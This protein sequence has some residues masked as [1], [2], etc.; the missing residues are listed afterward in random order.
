MTTYYFADDGNDGNSGLTTSLPK[1][2]LSHAATL[3]AAGN[4]ILFKCGDRWQLASGT[5]GWAITGK[6]L[7]SECLIGVWNDDVSP[8]KPLFDGGTY[9]T[10][11]DDANWT[12][13]G[14]GVWQRTLSATVTRIFAG[15]TT[16]TVTNESWGEPMSL[17]TSAGNV[18]AELEYHNS[19]GVITIYTGSVS[20][21]P[22]TFYDGLLCIGNGRATAEGVHLLRCQNVTLENLR[23][24][25]A[26]NTVSIGCQGTNDSDGIILRDVESHAASRLGSALRP[27]NT[28]ASGFWVRNTELI[29]CLADNHTAA[30]E[31]DN[32]SGNWGSNNGISFT[33]Q[34]IDTEVV[35][36]IVRGGFRHSSIQFQNDG[37]T[38]IYTGSNLN[39]YRTRQDMGIVYCESDYE[40]P[41]DGN[42]TNWTV[43]GLEIRTPIT[44]SQFAGSGTLKGVKF[45]G[46]R[47]ATHSQNIGTDQ[48]LWFQNWS[49]PDYRAMGAIT[50]DSC[51]I[52]NPYGA[53]IAMLEDRSAA[54]VSANAGWAASALTFTRNRII[55]LSPGG[56]RTYSVDH[57]VQGSPFQAAATDTFTSNI[58]ITAL[59]TCIR[60]EESTGV[61]TSRDVDTSAGS[62][63]ASGNVRA[64][65]LALAG[66]VPRLR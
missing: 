47:Q 58:F 6:V 37:T 51:T 4:E 54:G 60:H 40:H 24:A 41:F 30:S 7:A 12:H 53:P 3:V 17:Q 10:S 14:A 42:F 57:Q 63:T 62:L 11:S 15:T 64:A 9:L 36:P 45:L 35:D 18:N 1:T 26:Q 39:I 50:V 44:R 20:V 48:I 27:D 46:C 55:D 13:L 23:F 34:V 16:T 8:L 38:T 22:P 59:T 49:S 43:N 32:N 33:G 19:S 65:S 66:I 5:T 52:E 21:A 56:S 28:T 31:N 61:F 29:R 2:S 25:N